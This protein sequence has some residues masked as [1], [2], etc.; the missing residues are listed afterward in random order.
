MRG[1]E[2][3]DLA[4]RVRT[5]AEAVPDLTLLVLVAAEQQL[6]VAAVTASGSANPD[7]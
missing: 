7:R 2:A 5:V 1:I 6:L 4:R 3:E